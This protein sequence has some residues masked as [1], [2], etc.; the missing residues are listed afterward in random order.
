VSR[1]PDSATT[2]KPSFK[3]LLSLL[4]ELCSAMKSTCTFILPS[5][6]DK[7]TFEDFGSAANLTITKDDTIFL[8]GMGAK[9]AVSQ[10][11]EQIRGLIATTTSEY[12]KEKL[13]ERLAKIS[14]GVAVIKVGGSS[15]VEV[16]E[17]KDRFVDALNA[18]RA[19]V[20]EGIVPGGGTALL[21]YSSNSESVTRACFP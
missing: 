13:Q 2:A 12:E 20:E 17:K 9:E 7:L 15:E 5:K 18:T 1:P 14:G 3:M 19:A 16:G 10:R 11:A 6:L 4:E 8:N 21:V